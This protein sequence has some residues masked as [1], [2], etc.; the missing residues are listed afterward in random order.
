MTDQSRGQRGSPDVSPISDAPS[1]SQGRSPPS[2]SGRYNSN[3]PVPKKNLKK[4]WKLPSAST[5]SPDQESSTVRWDEYS[6]EPTDSEKGKPP[7]TTPGAVKL[8]EDPSP[9]RLNQN[10]GSSTQTTGG[11]VTAR[12]RVGSREISDAQILMR[13]EWKGAGG[14]HSIV[15]PMLDKPL[16]PGQSP[17]FP[18]GQHKKQLE[19]EAME[20]AEKE[21]REKEKAEQ[22]RIEQQRQE[23]ERA[24]QKR[25]DRELEEQR[26]RGQEREEQARQ[27]HMRAEQEQR[28]RGRLEQARRERD[29]VQKE[30][31]HQGVHQEEQPKGPQDEQSEAEQNTLSKPLS[32]TFQP[33][34]HNAAIQPR[35]QIDN[36]ELSQP[37]FA[38]GSS[39]T[40]SSELATRS[41]S[42]H[43][44]SASASPR[45]A[46]LAAED[47]RS[48]LARNPSNEEMKESRA[49]AL[50]SPLVSNPSNE[51]MKDRRAQALPQLPVQGGQETSPTIP[52]LN[53]KP[54][55]PF[56]SPVPNDGPAGRDSSL[57]ESRFRADLQHMS[58][59]D[60]LPSRFSATT[61]ATTSYD[62]SPPA[63]PEMGSTTSPTSATPNSVL[64]RKRPVPAA[65]IPS[66]K[67]TTRKPTPS[68]VPRTPPSLEKRDSKSLPKAPEN[69]EPVSPV[70]TLQA[71]RDALRRRK[72]NIETVIYELTHVV[73]PSSIAYDKASRQEI[74]K[75][76]D[77]LSKELA[78]VVKDEHE[79]GLKLHRAWKRHDDFAAYEPTS[80][81]VR[82]V[83]S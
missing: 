77:Q 33:A 11:A 48:P 36:K 5:G 27:D 74:K 41:A 25:Q 80:I 35:I 37:G 3:L 73:Q 31:E 16:P 60:Q 43:S 54:S 13:P 62:D 65:G 20:L 63:T 19:Q 64:N 28:M 79:T 69:V 9:R 38:I 17:T 18:V 67:A 6:G 32:P 46:S 76:V 10:F 61:Y 70:Q 2:K 50:R 44:A 8:H 24:E 75:T 55:Q 68:A 15:K 26:R 42:E 66:S 58:L 51:E 21:L 12:K 57:I 22:R 47:T 56:L 83:T 53:R 52:N 49:H 30:E 39:S 4:F 82:R 81:W 14:R 71:K 34:S 78:D 7:S 23:E 29:R 59:Q 40:S 1:L 72:R 45:L